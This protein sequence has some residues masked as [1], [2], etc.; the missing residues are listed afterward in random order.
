VDVGE[1]PWL[2]LKDGMGVDRNA[3]PGLGLVFGAKTGHACIDMPVSLVMVRRMSS[4]SCKMT[5]NSSAKCHR[6]IKK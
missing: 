6:Q 3:W 5:I 1:D 2:A 4:R